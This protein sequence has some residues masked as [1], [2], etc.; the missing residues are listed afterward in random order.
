MCV[1][2]HTLYTI[3]IVINNHNHNIMI[4]FHYI[5]IAVPSRALGFVLF[6]FIPV[7]HSL[8]HIAKKR[9]RTARCNRTGTKGQGPAGELRW[10]THNSLWVGF[11][12]TS[13]YVY[14]FSFGLSLWRQL[15]QYFLPLRSELMD[16]NPLT[17]KLLCQ[18]E[19]LLYELSNQ[20]RL[21]KWQQGT[22]FQ[23]MPSQQ[24]LP[25]CR[26]QWVIP[27]L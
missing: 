12:G 20:H 26:I 14:L 13:S 5:P 2:I 24:N 15:L 10:F 7:N 3:I 18:K 25:G 9:C 23:M 19:L 22:S 6:C 16:L 11:E 1:F 27:S 21:W 17:S 8:L 4:R